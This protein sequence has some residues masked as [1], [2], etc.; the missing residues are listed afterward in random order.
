MTGLGLIEALLKERLV[1]EK[2]VEAARELQIGA[3]KPVHELLVEMGFLGEEDLMRVSSRVFNMP[4]SRLKEET[5]DLDIAE[6][7]PYE[8]AK[9]YGVFPL[10]KENGTLVLA[11][12]NPQDVIALDEI[13]LLKKMPIKLVL[14]TKTEIAEHIEEYYQSDDSIYN[15]LKNIVT[16]ADVKVEILKDINPDEGVVDIDE[17]KS[18]NA[19]VI[20]LAN[21][22]LSDAIKARASDIHIEPQEDFTEIRYR[23]DGDLRTIMKVPAKLH[24]ALV[25]RIKILAEL[26]I[27][28]KRKAQDGRT[29]VLINDR[30]VDIRVSIVPTFCGEKCV[31]RLLDTKEAKTDLNKIGIGKDDLVVFTREI[32]RPQGIVLATGPTGSGKTSTLYA[33]LG[34]IKNETLNIVTVE[35]P[36]EYRVRGINQ[37]QVNPVKDLTFATGLRSILRQDPNVMLVGE[38]RD[39]ETAD[40][41]FRSALT[42]HLVLSTVHTNNAVATITRLRDIGLE[43]Y[44]IASALNL[45]VAQRLVRCICPDCKQ[46]YSPE[47]VLRN[48]FRTQL[49][50]AHIEKFYKGRGCDKCG[51]IGFKG[52]TGIFEILKLNK[53]IRDLIDKSAGEEE[54]FEEARKNGMRTLAEAGIALVAEGVTTMEEVIKV[55]D[56]EE[57]SLAEL[58]K[59]ERKMPKILI[60][61]DEGDLLD[62]LEKRFSSEGY[63]VIK[64]R[65]GKEA[66]EMAS[67][68][69][70]DLVIMDIMMPEMDGFEATRVLRSRLETAVIPIMMLTAKG[71]SGNEMEGFDAGADDYVTKPFDKDTFLARVRLLLKTR[72]RA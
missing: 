63:E 64:A 43:P 54:I 66:I 26:D 6:I 69:K 42:G 25:T 39:R 58:K 17:L 3:K 29:K 14:S 2:Q 12:S 18:D 21:L 31:M 62:V 70:P 56:V 11:T 53:K 51:Y 34:F 4:I 1:T 40:I 35:D 50:A 41:A 5:I 49:E 47:D 67:R 22:C 10:R 68:E 19:P 32:S 27:A 46:E 48:K 24:S 61:D 8:M 28:E 57:A 36:I 7:M 15:I 20:R 59:E 45:V 37:I 55:A 60:A 52:R 13:K 38:I 44:L 30:R 65:N 71:G 23:V 33:A 72:K 9:R 16:D